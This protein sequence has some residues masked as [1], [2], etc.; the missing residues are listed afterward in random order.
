MSEFKYIKSGLLKKFP[1]RS[2]I[3]A[4]TAIQPFGRGLSS[5]I[6]EKPLEQDC[7]IL[8]IVTR[9]KNQA[10][11]VQTLDSGIH[12]INHCLA[13]KYY[14]KQLRYPLDRNLSGG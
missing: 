10:Q 8:F 3:I 7:V 14:G 12:R 1:T 6:G 2:T 4:L 5:R 11:V 13:E 9:F